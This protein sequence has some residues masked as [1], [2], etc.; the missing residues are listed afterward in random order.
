[1]CTVSPMRY[2]TCNIIRNPG[3]LLPGII[4]VLLRLDFLLSRY[5]GALCCFLDCCSTLSAACGDAS[6]AE[7]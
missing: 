7:K 5:S 4:E 2:V 1:M 3:I 6:R